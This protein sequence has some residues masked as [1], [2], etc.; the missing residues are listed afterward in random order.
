MPLQSPPDLDALLP[1]RGRMRLVEA[2]VEAAPGMAVTRSRAS[3]DWPLCRN[4]RVDP[5][6]MIELVAQSAAVSF[7]MDR[8]TSGG[9]VGDKFGFLVGIREARFFIDALA[10][11]DLLVTRVQD[12][13]VLEDYREIVGTVHR[14]QHL[15]AEITLQVVQAAPAKEDPK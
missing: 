6:V 3:G 9:P 14:G 7:G 1:Q 11:G 12:G 13:F 4:G 2:V 8:L 15:A 10:P 5:L